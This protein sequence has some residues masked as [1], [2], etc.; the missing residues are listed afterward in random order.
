MGQMREE[1][2]RMPQLEREEWSRLEE[3]KGCRE[4]KT[5]WPLNER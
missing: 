4:Y 3:R 5:T 2:T 1:F